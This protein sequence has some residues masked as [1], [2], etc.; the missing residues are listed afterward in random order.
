[1]FVRVICWIG[2]YLL[3]GRILDICL[4]EYFYRDD[5]RFQDFTEYDRMIGRRLWLIIFFI[6]VIRSVSFGVDLLVERKSNKTDKN[7][8]EDTMNK[9]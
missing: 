6:W 5:P 4:F 7:R 3:I 2:V 1:M 8:E 9:K